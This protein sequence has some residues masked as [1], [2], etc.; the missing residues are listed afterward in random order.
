M[1]AQTRVVVASMTCAT[2]AKRVASGQPSGHH[3]HDEQRAGIRGERSRSKCRRDLPR[4][5]MSGMVR[6][7]ED[8]H[9]SPMRIRDAAGHYI[10]AP[11]RRVATW[12]C[13]DYPGFP[14]PRR[15]ILTR[16]AV[17]G[18]IVHALCPDNLH[19]KS[20]RRQTS[21]DRETPKFSG[22]RETRFPRDTPS[23]ITCCGIARPSFYKRIYGK[24]GKNTRKN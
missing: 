15:D 13:R 11:T 3:E 5:G 8:G 16:H 4:T 1:E 14:S 17:L 21:G 9:I 19:W 2:R 7:P 10:L 18:I 20:S 22:G 6:A 24:S 12:R 23:N